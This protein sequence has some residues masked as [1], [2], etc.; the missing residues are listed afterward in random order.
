MKLPSLRTT[1]FLAC[2]PLLPS[3]TDPLSP[4]DELR[5]ARRRWEAR[6]IETYAYRISRY[7]ECVREFTRAADVMVVRG[8]VAR[9]RYVDDGSEVPAERLS[10]YATVEGLFEGVERALARNPA[11]LVVDYHP[12]LG[13]PERLEVDYDIQA[14]DDEFTVRASDLIPVTELRFYP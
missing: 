12:Q 5:D 3:C 8:V 9:A 14:A 11:R 13:Y 10:M 7:C 4:Q 1:L 2:L 6:R